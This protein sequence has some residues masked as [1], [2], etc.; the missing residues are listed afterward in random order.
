MDILQIVVEII[1]EV[2][3]L[4]EIQI[5]FSLL[6]IYFAYRGFENG[7]YNL[8]DINNEHIRKH[9]NILIRLSMLKRETLL[10]IS[11]FIQ[12]VFTYCMIVGIQ[13]GE[14]YY[15]SSIISVT[16]LLILTTFFVQLLIFGVLDFIYDIVYKRDSIEN[17]LPI[18]R[19]N[20]HKIYGILIMLLTAIMNL[21]TPSIWISNNREI[22]YFT[23]LYLFS[24]KYSLIGNNIH[25]VNILLWLICLIPIILL[26]LKSNKLR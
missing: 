7:K 11:M 21:V 22:G 16:V 1:S 3:K 24:E 9:K 18:Y 6:A 10:P 23:S 26:A 12:L 4:G 19:I 2:I 13:L 8:Y 25:I 20:I 15:T 14:L 17:N 5:F